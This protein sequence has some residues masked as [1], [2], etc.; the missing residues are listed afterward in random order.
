MPLMMEHTFY[1]EAHL[2][3]LL[4]LFR[5]VPQL[6]HPFSPPLSLLVSSLPP[7]LPFHHYFSFCLSPSPHLLPLF[8]LLLLLLPLFPLLLLLL[9]L[10]RLLFFLLHHSSPLC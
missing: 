7:C 9:L 1:F 4:F 6:L 2:L 3:F 8:P 10:S 5:F